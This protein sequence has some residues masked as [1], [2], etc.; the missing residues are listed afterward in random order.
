MPTQQL[1][2]L[3]CS[4][5]RGN[6]G[7]L[8]HGSDLTALSVPRKT[9]TS[10]ANAISE[11]SLHRGNHA[12]STPAESPRSAVDQ[13]PQAEAAPAGAAPKEALQA[14]G[15]HLAEGSGLVS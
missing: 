12:D 4:Q 13:S 7:V 15:T 8:R 1:V 3:L 11:I 10:S 5:E 2:L 6:A 14:L 9:F